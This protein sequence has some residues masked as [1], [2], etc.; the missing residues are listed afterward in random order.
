MLVIV[1]WLLFL[2]VRKVASVRVGR[3]IDKETASRATFTE[4]HSRARRSVCAHYLFGRNSKDSERASVQQSVFAC[5]SHRGP[6]W[7]ARPESSALL[8]ARAFE[9][10]PCSLCSRQLVC[11]FWC[12]ADNRGT[13]NALRPS[14]HSAPRLVSKRLAQIQGRHAHAPLNQYGQSF[15]IFILLPT[16][17]A[18]VIKILFE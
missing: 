12:A 5:R 8:F 9:R 13:W 7:R 6:D 17:V 16:Y 3:K 11:Y 14:V 10:S 1:I 18:R 2:T 4:S 15:F